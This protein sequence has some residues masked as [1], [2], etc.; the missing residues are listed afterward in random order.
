MGSNP[1]TTQTWLCDESDGLLCHPAAPQ[2]VHCATNSEL[3][4]LQLGDK[5][6]TH[7]SGHPWRLNLEANSFAAGAPSPQSQAQAL[8]QS[9]EL[10]SYRLALGLGANDLPL[11][12]DGN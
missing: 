4:R 6:H 2:G 3:E 5:A 12:D 8:H 10:N 7:T 11:E 9:S 1:S